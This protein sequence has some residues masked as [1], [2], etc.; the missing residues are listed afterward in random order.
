VV[1]ETRE[2]GHAAVTIRVRVPVLDILIHQRDAVSAASSEVALVHL[3]LR[4]IAVD[5]GQPLDEPVCRCG[6]GRGQCFLGGHHRGGAVP[7]PACGATHCT[8]ASVMGARK[9]ERE[10]LL[11][12][13]DGGAVGSDGLLCSASS[14]RQAHVLA[15][16]WCV[17]LLEKAGVLEVADVSRDATFGDVDRIV[18]TDV[19]QRTRFSHAHFR[20]DPQP[21][22]RVRELGHRR[23]GVR[24]D[25]V[26]SVCAILGGVPGFGKI[27]DG[28]CP[29]WMPRDEVLLKAGRDDQPEVNGL[30]ERCERVESARYGSAVLNVGPCLAVEVERHHGRACGL[31]EEGDG[32]AAKRGETGVQ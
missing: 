20:D 16:A 6:A 11:G 12:R 30:R 24:L 23:P 25:I 2:V 13:R 22:G 15:A 3:P 10:F 17:G 31:L 32:A 28:L 19:T 26:V 4:E 7:L 18:R 27:C 1:V 9:T 8:C 5:A 21:T 14:R 29:V